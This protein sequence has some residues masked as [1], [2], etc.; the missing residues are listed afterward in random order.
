MNIFEQDIR[1]FREGDVRAIEYRIFEVHNP[2]ASKT[3]QLEHKL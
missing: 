2:M 3:A 1:S